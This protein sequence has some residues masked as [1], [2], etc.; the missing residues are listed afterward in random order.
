MTAKTCPPFGAGSVD[1]AQVHAA[2]L[3]GEDLDKAVRDATVRP[4][5]DK[6]AKAPPAPEP[7]APATKPGK[8]AQ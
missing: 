7:A 1:F 6:P 5:A 2:A 8:G 3:K 4:G